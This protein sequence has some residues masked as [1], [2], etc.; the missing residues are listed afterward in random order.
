LDFGTLTSVAA[1][2]VRGGINMNITNH[3]NSN[4]AAIAAAEHDNYWFSKPNVFMYGEAVVTG[5]GTY[6]NPANM[7]WQFPEGFGDANYFLDGRLEYAVRR[8]HSNFLNHP[9]TQM[10]S[11]LLPIPPILGIA[12]KVASRI[13]S[14]NGFL[15]RGFTVKAPF[16]IPVQRFG[17]MS[18]GR[19]DYWGPRI[20]TG[21]FVNRTFAAIKPSWNP[22][23]QYTTGVIPKGTSIRF[24]LIGPQGLKYPGGS[25]QFM[26]E[27][28]SIINQASK[29]IIR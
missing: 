29:M 5:N 4:A 1:G 23:T 24:G 16:N 19:P 3:I 25:I 27:S 12:G 17:N 2:G 6:T 7:S 14:K 13:T 28:N 9:I 20:G 10:Y 26:V 22:L 11:A 18:L 8:G 15:F 21:K